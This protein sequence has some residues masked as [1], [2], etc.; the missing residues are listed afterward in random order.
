MRKVLKPYEVTYPNAIR[1]RKGSSLLILR[2]ETNP[3]RMGWLWCRSEDGQ[4]RRF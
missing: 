1:V 4:E 3:A 2:E